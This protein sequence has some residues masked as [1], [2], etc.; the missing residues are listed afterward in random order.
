M[1]LPVLLSEEVPPMPETVPVSV[2]VSV[3]ASVAVTVSVLSGGDSKS[4]IS[5]RR[6]SSPPSTNIAAKLVRSVFA[7]LLTSDLSILY[8]QILF[9]CPSS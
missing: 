6:S 9:F 7:A 5:R 8:P 3:S 2:S 4:T 1:L